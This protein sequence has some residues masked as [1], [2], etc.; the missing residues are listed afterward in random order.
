MASV[1]KGKGVRI[2]KS[3]LLCKNGCGFYGNPSWQGYCSKCWREVKQA[4]VE[5]EHVKP[6]LG[7][8]L[9]FLIASSCHVH[10]DEKLGGIIDP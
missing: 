8:K 6:N 4:Q 1:K 7:K 9:V 5:Q 10:I 3:D 2:E